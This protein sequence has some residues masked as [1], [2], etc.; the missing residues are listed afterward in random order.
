MSRDTLSQPNKST[1]VRIQ[2]PTPVR[3]CAR[4]ASRIAP[5][6][7]SRA[8]A[9]LYAHPHGA[10]RR[11]PREEQW[12]RDGTPFELDCRGRTLAAWSWGDGPTV[13]LH[14]GWNG[15]GAQ[16]GAFVGPLVEAGY[17]VVTYDAPAHGDSP[18]R[19]TTGVDMARTIAEASRQLNGLHAVVAHSLGSMATGYAL[20]ERL[21]VD[22]AVFIAPPADMVAYTRAFVE[23]VGFTDTVHDEM[24]RHYERTLNMDWS[25]FNM[26][27]FARENRRVQGRQTPLLV[28][29]D[30]DD[31]EVPWESGQRA[32][33]AWRD[34]ELHL[35]R[36]LGHRRILRNEE[37]V[38]KVVDFL[39]ADL[40][41]KL[42][43]ASLDAA[44][45]PRDPAET[46][47]A[48]ARLHS[49]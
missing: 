49:R 23:A 45:T 39:Q 40:G 25:A 21:P 22:R 31:K 44:V 4:L 29:H 34:S 47:S 35:T 42:G 18:G 17:S 38:G 1:N 27:S 7:T 16:L 9:L 15:R 33:D 20:Q 12:L 28:I 46:V 6:L 10:N 43:G 26:E 5:G 24:I 30:R 32:H 48:T 3:G 37:V 8:A 2:L 41:R 11:P 14:H 13:L 36:R 19:Y